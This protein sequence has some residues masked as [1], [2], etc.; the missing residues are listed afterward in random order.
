MSSRGPSPKATIGT[1]SPESADGAVGNFVG[2]KGGAGVWQQIISQMPPH[3][4]YIE[5]FLGTGV[6]MQRKRPAV[7]SIGID[8]NPAVIKVARRNLSG[9]GRAFQ[10]EDALEFLAS[11]V[12]SFLLPNTLIYCD[13]PYL[14]STRGHRQY[15]R[16]EFSDLQHIELLRVLKSLPCKVILSGYWSELYA[17]KLKGWRTHKF[18]TTT[19]GGGRVEEWLWMNF[20]EPFELFDTRFLGSNFRERERIKRKRNRW[21]NRLRTMS[22][23]DRAAILDAISE[24]RAN[25]ST[26]AALTPRRD[27]KLRK[28]RTPTNR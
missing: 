16:N 23:L 18:Y 11:K 12:V 4:I 9:P 19:R 27:A 2:A 6:V 1:A 22:R 5:P 13:P 21:V 28:L 7:S 8:I 17:S 25:M 15:Y 24:A 14:L 3:A 10:C 20:P 26:D